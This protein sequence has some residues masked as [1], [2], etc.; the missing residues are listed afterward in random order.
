MSSN[1]YHDCLLSFK[2]LHDFVA[3]DPIMLKFRNRELVYSLRN[4]RPL[5]KESSLS[6]FGFFSTVNRLRRSWD[7]FPRSGT[8]VSVLSGFKSKLKNFVFSF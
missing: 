2:V 1:R 6:N 4:H 8:E 3:C 5:C 7:V